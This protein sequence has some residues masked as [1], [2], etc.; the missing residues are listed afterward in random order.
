M[1][2]RP[3]ILAVPTLE[4]GLDPLLLDRLMQPA[5]E[6]LDHSMRDVRRSGAFDDPMFISCGV[7]RV[8]SQSDSGRDFLQQFRE[9]FDGTLARATLFDSLHSKRRR[10][11]LAR[12]NTEVVRRG[13]GELPDILARFPELKGR[14]IFAVDG[15]H[16]LNRP[17]G[18]P[19]GQ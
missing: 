11:L 5:D 4:S 3:S 2:I 14:A 1:P 13:R 12:L 15:H 16:G 10:D 17:L 9:V 18:M 7:R 19:V 8:V 6:A